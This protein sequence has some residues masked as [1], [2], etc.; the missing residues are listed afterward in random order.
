MD[1][2]KSR[3]RAPQCDDTSLQFG[4]FEFGLFGLFEIAVVLVILFDV[5]WLSA[6]GCYLA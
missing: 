3:L 1:S 2:N 5:L 4:L 6:D